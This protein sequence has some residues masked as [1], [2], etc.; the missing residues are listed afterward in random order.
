MAMQLY[1]EAL[2]RVGKDLT[3]SKFIQV[4]EGIK[5][6]DSSWLPIISFSPTYHEGITGKRYV[7]FE[8]GVPKIIEM[9]IK[10]D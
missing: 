6:Y 1:A 5:N 4:L 10:M 3:R 8:D 2:K 9:A 7:C